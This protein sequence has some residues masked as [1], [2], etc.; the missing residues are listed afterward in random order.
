MT[1]KELTDLAVKWLRR[2]NSAKGHGCLVA[3]SELRS[4]W[5][6]EI[7]D[8]VGF[9][10]NGNGV[11]SVVVEAKVSRSDFLAD[12][13]K[14]HRVAGGIGNYR[15]F[16]CPEGVIYPS[17]LPKGWGLVW[18][19]SR[20]HLKVKEGPA[21]YFGGSYLVAT[22]KLAD[23]LHEADTIREAWLLVRL[24][25]RVGDAEQM[26]SWIKE[27]NRAKNHYQAEAERLRLENR[28]LRLEALQ[29]RKEM[30]VPA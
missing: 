21:A 19:N 15:Y 4:G 2:P 12:K 28:T 9:R 10:L 1:H 25:S 23:W 6:G 5:N 22:Q 24:L 16:I 14:P 3:A 29:L 20:G 7:P 17:D 26:N 30:L 27:A 13:N 18:V 8:A 11:I